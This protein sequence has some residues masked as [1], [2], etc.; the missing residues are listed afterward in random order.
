MAK[1]LVKNTDPSLQANLIETLTAD[2]FGA[3]FLVNQLP[4]GGDAAAL[5]NL[6]TAVQQ[7]SLGGLRWPGGTVTETVFD[8]RHENATT[9][10]GNL[11]IGQH[12]FFAAAGTLHANVTLTLQT[13]SAFGADHMAATALA[14]GTYGNRHVDTQ[15]LADMKSY[16]ERTIAD[17]AASG[18]QIHTFEIG[19]EFWGGG[20]MTA[21]EYGR[22]ARAMLVTVNAAI[23]EA[24]PAGTIRPTVAIQSLCAAGYMS[25]A[26]TSAVYVHDG[27]VDNQNHPGWTK[28]MIPGQ[29]VAYQQVLQIADEVTGKTEGG[30]N[31][32]HLVDGM[33][34][35]FY[36]K[37]GLAGINGDAETFIFK[38]LNTLEHR[39]GFAYGALDRNFTEWDPIRYVDANND[40]VN[41]TGASNRGMP[42]AAMMVDILYELTT[43]GATSADIWP[44]YFARANY[45]NLVGNTA[46]DVRVPG[47]AFALMSESLIGTHPLFDFKQSSAGVEL[48]VHGFASADRLVLMTAN[49]INAAA[50]T[51]SLSLN[52]VGDAALQDRL[53]H[54]TYFLTTTRLNAADSTGAADAGITNLG[55]HPVLTY[56]NGR[57]LTGDVVN[58]GNLAAWDLLR[59]EITF[60]GAGNDRV[61]GRGGNDLI[62]GLGGNDTLIGGAGQDMLTGGLGRDLLQGGL[63]DDNLKGQGGDDI[64]DGG[65]GND[66]LAG[67]GGADRF[68]FLNGFGKDEITDFHSA[69]HDIVDLSGMTG[70]DSVKTFADVKTLMH[71][72]GADTHIVFTTGELVLD[73]VN[74][75]TLTALD[76]LF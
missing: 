13:R 24:L 43:H 61:E 12:Q 39:L 32:A 51:A 28:F 21:T 19:N 1:F 3:N 58:L 54:G 5:A 2:H 41:D 66:I 20:E 8:F 72:E 59:T 50:A 23:D 18:T 45:T 7:L 17:A 27:Q 15:Y 65:A 73:N 22:V 35:H 55:V 47:A 46:C 64:L 44:L 10:N 33:I 56:G 48:A 49:E 76:F 37:D 9:M 30:A 52:A 34:D 16:I 69:E 38:Q 4:T 67:G 57:M 68:I 6:M 63:G 60:V 53:D 29:G 31:L 62:N 71:M 11:T 14:D 42:Q 75:T 36:P 25:P 70:A 40:G 26:A 74:A